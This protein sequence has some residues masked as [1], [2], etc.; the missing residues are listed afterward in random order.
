MTNEIKISIS[1]LLIG[2]I[3]LSIYWFIPID[4]YKVVAGEK[5]VKE[6]VF[7]AQYEA[8]VYQQIPEVK[9]YLK[10]LNQIIQSG[11]SF[12][13]LSNSE[14]DSSGIKVQHLLLADVRFNGDGKQ[15]NKLLH[16]DMMRI[17]PSIV[18]TLDSSTA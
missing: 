16:N 1:I 12:L 13:P 9:R 5:A 14:L 18:S 4:D 10:D 17:L 6:R 2:V 11:K 3:L 15:G 8:E 7:L